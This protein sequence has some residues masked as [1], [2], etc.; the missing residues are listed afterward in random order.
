MI[1]ETE[2]KLKRRKPMTTTSTITA[3][4][5]VLSLTVIIMTSMTII[6]LP[7]SSFE[8]T[9]TTTNANQ[10]S[11]VQSQTKGVITPCNVTESTLQGPEYIANPPFREGQGFAKGTEGE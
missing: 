5:T 1:L 4:I 10:A 2:K 7:H 6:N 9:A 11:E 3:V 8:Q